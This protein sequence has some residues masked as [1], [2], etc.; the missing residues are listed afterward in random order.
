MGMYHFWRDHPPKKGDGFY[1]DPGST[2][3]PMLMYHQGVSGFDP[4]P[5]DPST[6]GQ[7]KVVTIAIALGGP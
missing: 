3:P 5:I 2:L 1:L 6:P 7:A 4:Q